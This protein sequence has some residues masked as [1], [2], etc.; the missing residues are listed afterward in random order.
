MSKLRPL[1]EESISAE[2]AVCSLYQELLH[3]WNERSATGMSNLF[4]EEGNLVGFDGSQI[5]GRT[6][7]ETHVSQIFRDHPTGSYVG[8]VREV[9]FL[10]PDI[11]ILRAVAGMVP[12]GQKELNPG[13]NTIQTLVAS[14]HTEDNGKWRIEV[15]QNTPAAFHSRPEDNHALTEELRELL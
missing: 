2:E 7:I 3:Q 13:L 12:P 10:T 6:E 14:K 5:N 15:Y 11:A 4:T 1:T 9:R 8:K